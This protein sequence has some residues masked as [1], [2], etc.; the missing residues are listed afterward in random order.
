MKYH[1][2]HED[3][4]KLTVV[5]LGLISYCISV[6]VLFISPNMNYSWYKNSEAKPFS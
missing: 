1:K 2:F 6:S 5:N 3:S 4:L